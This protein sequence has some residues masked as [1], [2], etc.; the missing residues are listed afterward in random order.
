MEQLPRAIVIA[1]II[2]GGA[3]L[4]RGLYPADRF[5]L[6]PAGNGAYRIDKLTG[7]VLYCDAVLCRALP[8]GAIVPTPRAVPPANSTGT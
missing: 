7:A 5:A 2:L 8:Y 4:I 3:T 1:A 6:V